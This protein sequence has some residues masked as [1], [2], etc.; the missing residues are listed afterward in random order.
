MSSTVKS[1]GF[2][3]VINS[4]KFLDEEVREEFQENSYNE[5]SDLSITYDGTIIYSDVNSHADYS[6]REYFYGFEVGT[7]M[8]ETN[9]KKFLSECEK[10]GI[11]IDHTTI[12]PYSCIWYNGSDCPVDEYTKEELI[13]KT[14]S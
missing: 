11:E 13:A 1:Y 3:A 5:K 12:A 14:K 7:N 6:T 9:L 2:M 10:Y 8:N 4:D